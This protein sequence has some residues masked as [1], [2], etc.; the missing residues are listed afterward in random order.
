MRKLE[1]LA[2]VLRVESSLAVPSEG[3]QTYYKII[4]LKPLEFCLLLLRTLYY[5]NII[6]TWRGNLPGTQCPLSIIT[7]HNSMPRHHRLYPGRVKCN[8]GRSV[9]SSLILVG[10]NQIHIMVDLD[11]TTA[12]LLGPTVGWARHGIINKCTSDL[13]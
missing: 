3:E 4:V 8:D 2:G 11:Y 1:L 10:D 6:R 5:A 12:Q 7:A 13:E 9:H